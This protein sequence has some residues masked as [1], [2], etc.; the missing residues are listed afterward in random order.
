MAKTKPSPFP[1]PP[2][3]AYYGADI[4]MLMIRRYGHAIAEEFR[5]DKMVLFGSHAY[6][7]PHADG[8]VDLL[9][10]MPTRDQHA[11]SFRALWRLA[12]PFLLDLFVHT[13]YQMR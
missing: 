1:L 5:A 8:D 9:V 7:M 13:P 2:K 11:Q 3:R 6:G 4:P 12:A 10:V